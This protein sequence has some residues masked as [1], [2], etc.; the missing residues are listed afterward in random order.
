MAL[1]LNA[2]TA[3]IIS[4]SKLTEPYMLPAYKLQLALNPSDSSLLNR[5]AAE[6][7]TFSLA[8]RDTGEAHFFINLNLRQQFQ[9]K[10]KGSR[11]PLKSLKSEN[12]T[13]VEKCYKTD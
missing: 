2:N 4:T 8:R 1:V 5:G 9:L 6:I 3:Q 12:R 11:I 13:G 10:V 7:L